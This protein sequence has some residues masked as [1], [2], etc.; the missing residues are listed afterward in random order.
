MILRA[1]IVAAMAILA[2]P[3]Q[4]QLLKCVGT[5]G[6]TTYQS[7]PCPVAAQEKRIREPD[8][9]P[10]ARGGRLKDGWMEDE[11]AF[12]AKACTAAIMVPL[13]GY[14]E[15]QSLAFPEARLSADVNRHC[16]C[17][18]RRLGTTHTKAEYLANT[19]AISR[20]IDQ[21]AITGGECRPEGSLA[22]LLRKAGAMR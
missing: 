8:A 12:I 4:A 7:D 17:L 14:H 3:A 5:D 1:G 22:D 21:E 2:D 16:T 15:R 9:G 10:G 19:D 18:A 13:K 6:K 11:I 20:R